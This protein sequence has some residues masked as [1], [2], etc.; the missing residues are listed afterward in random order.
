METFICKICG[1]QI[2]AEFIP[3]IEECNYCKHFIFEMETGKS[4]SLKNGTPTHKR[5]TLN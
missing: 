5:K 1:K 3:T 4:R 2:T